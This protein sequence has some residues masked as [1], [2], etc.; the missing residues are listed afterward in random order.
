MAPLP[1]LVALLLGQ[2]VSCG[3][4][5]VLLPKTPDDPENHRAV[6]RR[7]RLAWSRRLV[8]DVREFFRPL[9]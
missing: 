2:S 7:A 1:R 3:R 4:K 8:G 5:Y 9:R 6:A